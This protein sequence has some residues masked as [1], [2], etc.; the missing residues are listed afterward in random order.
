MIKVIREEEKEQVVKAMHK[1][2][3]FHTDLEVYI[4][5]SDELYHSLTETQQGVYLIMS[6]TDKQLMRFK[7]NVTQTR[8]I[9]LEIVTMDKQELDVPELEQ[10]KRFIIDKRLPYDEYM[11]LQDSDGD[12]RDYG[13]LPTVGDYIYGAS[14]RL[15]F[16]INKDTEEMYTIDR[17]SFN[18]ALANLINLYDFKEPIINEVSIKVSLPEDQMQIHEL[19]NAVYYKQETYIQVVSTKM[20]IE[21]FRTPPHWGKVNFKPEHLLV[22][23]KPAELFPHMMKI[24]TA[25]DP[26]PDKPFMRRDIFTLTYPHDLL[27]IVNL[28]YSEFI[29]E[30]NSTLKL[31]E[32]EIIKVE[33]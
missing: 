24:K 21:A 15:I 23:C 28:K 26:V 29:R 1:G 18:V 9:Q 19:N 31:H 30:T 25:S 14:N 8:L 13:E 6:L 17:N 5:E 20:L 16:F 3:G 2:Y 32:R 22:H 12:N 27:N 4:S 11:E 33:E 7:Y 10:Y